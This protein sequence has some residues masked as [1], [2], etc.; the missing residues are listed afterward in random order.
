M[1]RNCVWV[2]EV[3]VLNAVRDTI[4][5]WEVWSSWN[6]LQEARNELRKMRDSKPSWESAKFFDETARIKK[7]EAVRP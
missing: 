2:I 7:Y 5:K 6:T 3:G 4:R 1:K